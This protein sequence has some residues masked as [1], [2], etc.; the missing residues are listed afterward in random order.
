MDACQ[1]KR[2]AFLSCDLW[3]TSIKQLKINFGTTHSNAYISCNRKIEHI[4]WN[5]I[6]YSNTP[7]FPVRGKIIWIRKYI[8][9]GSERKDR[10]NRKVYHQWSMLFPS[11]RSYPGFPRICFTFGRFLFLKL[12]YIMNAWYFKD[13][14]QLLETMCPLFQRGVALCAITE[15]TTGWLICK[16]GSSLWWPPRCETLWCRRSGILH[17][18]LPFRR[19]WTHSKRWRGYD[20][21]RQNIQRWQSY[22]FQLKF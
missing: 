18:F 8:I 15:W 9:R 5:C 12:F 10:M 3:Q 13:H 14:L 6:Q 22:K 7:G 4:F 2:E 17:L 11:C 1:W 16:V 21:L 20:K 19:C